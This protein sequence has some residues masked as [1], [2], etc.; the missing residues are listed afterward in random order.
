MT[1]LHDEL[2]E[3]RERQ[4]ITLDSLHAAT[5]ISRDAL[6]AIE[7]GDF[8]FLPKT[9]LRLFLRTYAAHVGMDPQYVLDRYE[10]LIAPPPGEAPATL[11]Q[12][13]PIPW[14]RVVA[15]TV[16]FFLLGWAGITAFKNRAGDRYPTDYAAGRPLV[17]SPGALQAGA[18]PESVDLS[19]GMAGHAAL[20]DS[21]L[22]AVSSSGTL[23]D[24]AVDL[25]A[26][27]GPAWWGLDSLVVL[28]G[29]CLE[30]TWLDVSIDGQRAFQGEMKPGEERTWT[31]RDRFYVVAGRSSGI[32]FLLQGKPLSRAH[33]WASEVLRMGITRKGIEVEKK[34]R[35]AESTEDSAAQP[36]GVRADTGQGQ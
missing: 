16:G 5:R 30:Q 12:E 6:E 13:R 3:G 27:R 20:P 7:R 34:R 36:R 18:A 19:Q 31:A 29:V 8:E 1:S 26:T 33:S 23:P 4:R 25:S 2:R 24:S 10:D 21:G 32:Q 14:G 35:P 17:A 11:P 15:L 28:K 9:Y 22:P